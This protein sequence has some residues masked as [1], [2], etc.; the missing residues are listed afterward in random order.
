LSQTHPIPGTGKSSLVQAIATEYDLEL[1]VFHLEAMDD[2]ALEKAFQKLPKRCIALFEDIDSAGIVR[3]DPKAKKV[4]EA[5]AA[6]HSNS[7]ADYEED[8]D[9]DY[10]EQPAHTHK[11]KTNEAAAQAKTPAKT[12]VTL[13]GLLNTLDGPGAKEGRLV[14]LTTNAPKS[15]DAALIRSG[16]ID[17]RFYMGFSTPMTAAITFERMFGT[18]PVNQLPKKAIR[19]FAMQFGRMVPEKTFTP[20]Q[21]Q[22]YCT[23]YR[24]QPG[25]ALENFPKWIE[26]S[27]NGQSNFEYDINEDGPGDRAPTKATEEWNKMLDAWQNGEY[28]QQMETTKVA[29]MVLP[30]PCFNPPPRTTSRGLWG[31]AK[32]T[33][34][35]NHTDDK[36][37]PLAYGTDQPDLY[38]DRLVDPRQSL[39]HFGT[40]LERWSMR[41][42]PTTKSIIS[43]TALITQPRTRF[44]NAGTRRRYSHQS[45]RPSSSGRLKSDL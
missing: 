10:E 43:H 11:P 39:E 45:A 8:Y 30:S 34:S 38:V 25:A 9:E 28:E 7:G 22:E 16:R 44:S 20:C 13:S 29:A 21:I 31:A 6:E 26:D 19:S 27:A 23:E 15:L 4:A 12:T 18:D 2:A 37:Y 41:M 32:N 5:D 35:G 3:E 42:I 33:G 1:H 36:E 14:I 24:N 40:L 17:K